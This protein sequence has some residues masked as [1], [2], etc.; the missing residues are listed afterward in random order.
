MQGLATLHVTITR[1]EVQR[2][3]SSAAVLL[4]RM[5]CNMRAH[6]SEGRG[7]AANEFPNRSSYS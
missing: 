2:L 4:H 7:E 6:K 5:Q 1:P 3:C